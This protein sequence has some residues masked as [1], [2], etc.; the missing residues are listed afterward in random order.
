MNARISG[1]RAA[2]L[3]E[4]RLW[5]T[6]LAL[7][8]VLA[9]LVTGRFWIAVL[10]EGHFRPEWIFEAYSELL[11]GVL[12]LI[13]PILYRLVFGLLPLQQLRLR[14]ASAP[15]PLDQY[16]G[17]MSDRAADAKLSVIVPVARASG[18][19]PDVDALSV[20]RTLTSSSRLLS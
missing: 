20:L 6:E 17:S 14:R 15:A 5:I 9:F 4:T 8:A 19:T 1:E 2:Q 3:R 11:L 13:F 12:C 10:R 7:W 18:A 16:P